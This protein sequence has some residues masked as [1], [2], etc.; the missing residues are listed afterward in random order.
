MSLPKDILD[1]FD[2]WEEWKKLRAMPAKVEQLEQR[3]AALESRPDRAPFGAH[4][5][6]QYHWKCDE[7]GYTDLKIDAKAR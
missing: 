3:L 4:G 7:C 2:R 5:M 6:R 1:Y